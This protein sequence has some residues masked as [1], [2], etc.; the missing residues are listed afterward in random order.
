MHHERSIFLYNAHTGES[1]KTTYWAGGHYQP[2]AL[3]QINH[4]LRDHYSGSVHRMDPKVIDLM[5]RLH[6]LSPKK[7][8]VVLSGYRT[9]DTNA[10]LAET[11][12]GVAVH[13]QHIEGKAV[14]IVLEGVSLHHLA[15]AAK[16]L[17]M[18]GVGTYPA[19]GFVHVDT[20]RVRYW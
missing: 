2:D 19:S 15:K 16:S 4:I 9:P 20:G 10:M 13:S 1:L 12:E 6:G 8:F 17:K 7:P 3:H 14:D 11:T 18:G 5:Q